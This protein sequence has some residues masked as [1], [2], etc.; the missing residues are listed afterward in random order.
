MKE[1]MFKIRANGEKIKS[2]SIT[3]EEIESRS[4]EAIAKREEL[5]KEIENVTEEGIDELET[6][7]KEQDKLVEGI[8]AEKEEAD[9]VKE[10]L[11]KEFDELQKELDEIQDEEDKEPKGEERKMNKELET[12]TAAVT[13]YIKT[14]A[15]PAD[16]LVSSE[17]G[18]LIPEEIVYNPQAEVSSKTDLSN[19]V[20]KAKVGTK[21]GSYPILK[22]NTQ[23]LNTVAELEENPAL[24][25][26]DF[27]EV[28]WSVETYRGALAVS[29][30]AIDD[31]E[32]DLMGI[33]ADQA[34]AVKQNTVNAKIAGEFKKFTAKDAEGVDGLKDIINVEL[35]PAYDVRIVASQTAFNMLDKFKDKEGRYLLQDT[36]AFESGKQ[37]LGK[38]VIVV[39]DDL[40]GKGTVFVGDT[41]RAVLFADRKDIGVRWTDHH[42]YGE[43]LMAG[44]RMDIKQ[45]DKKAGFYVTLK[46]VP[47]GE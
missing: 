34:R 37:V 30:E 42:I 15:L 43:Y 12:R 25:K 9:K 23:V 4:K 44:L 19:L 11:D 41:K 17:I 10:D 13:D 40:I 45:A 28:K 33:V 39:A 22:N 18:V 24:S 20:T 38:E 6:Q 21:S 8:E 47:A 46:D 27:E 29:R 31:S 7:L 26:P 3:L 5:A 1:L 14:R 2:H 16:G 35:D 36:I 32:V